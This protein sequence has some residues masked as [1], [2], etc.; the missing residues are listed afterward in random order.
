MIAAASHHRLHVGHVVDCFGAGGIATGV[1]ELIRATQGAVRHSII[2]LVDD[3]RLLDQLQP[4]PR[5]YVLKPGRTRLLGF[6]SRLAWL[7]CRHHIDILH[8]NNHFAW[9]DSALT[10]RLTGCLCLATFHGVEKPLAEMPRD[11]RAKCRVAARLGSAATAVSAASR[12]M[13][14]TLSG[15][16][17]RAVQVIPNGVDVGRFVVCAPDA[18]QRRELREVLGVPPATE[19]AVHVAGLRPIKDQVT[20]LRAW[21]QTLSARG[22]DGGPMPVLLVAGEGQCGPALQALARELGIAGNVRFLGQRR[23]LNTLLPAC[24]LFVLSS[25]SEGMS[26]AILEAMAAALPVVATRVGGNGELVQDGKTGTLVPARDPAAL[27]GALVEL[28]RDPAQRLR[29]GLRARQVAEQQ[30]DQAVTA[31]RYLDIYRH[32]AGTVVRPEPA[33]AAV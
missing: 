4:E 29:F 21:Q 10:A 25:L 13:V 8:C 32:L 18:P 16:P 31:K 33:L 30:F 15:L 3:L 6:S 17:P 11:I 20:L 2:S 24:D 1:L 26:F 19:L 14:C 9:L 12:T 23:D 22:G 27:A 28:L 7:V 5:A